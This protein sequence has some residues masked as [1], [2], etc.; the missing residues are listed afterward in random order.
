MN[1]QRYETF[2]VNSSDNEPPSAASRHRDG[3]WHS[4]LL[5]LQRG[6][7]A[8]QKMK[9]SSSPTIPLF[10]LFLLAFHLFCLFLAFLLL[11]LVAT[12]GRAGCGARTAFRTCSLGL[13]P[14][15]SVHPNDS[16]LELAAPS[17]DY[18]CYRPVV[19]LG[20]HALDGIQCGVALNNLP[21]DTVLAI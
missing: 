10:L 16:P 9:P 13:F 12:V 5:G 14:L 6:Q 20:L 11:L 2:T 8:T 18:R 7:Q 19:R 3:G 21:E 1:F 15:D 17:N 4:R